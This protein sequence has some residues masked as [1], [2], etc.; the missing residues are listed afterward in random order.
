MIMVIYYYCH[1]YIVP[2]RTINLFM[3]IC[4]TRIQVWNSDYLRR[5][6]FYV[7]INSKWTNSM[8]IIKI[9]YNKKGTLLNFQRHTKETLLTP[10]TMICQQLSVYFA[11]NKSL[12][13]SMIRYFF[14]HDLKINIADILIKPRL[15]WSDLVTPCLSSNWNLYFL[16]W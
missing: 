9:N 10:I 14:N 3:K 16:S 11:K 2:L 6:D 4:L 1:N 5:E 8:I 15:I 13:A 12:S 7:I